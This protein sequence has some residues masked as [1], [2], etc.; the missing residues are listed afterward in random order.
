MTTSQKQH[1]NKTSISN[2]LNL[3]FLF[4]VLRV[5]GSIDSDSISVGL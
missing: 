3:T 1:E 4:E 5:I 2:V